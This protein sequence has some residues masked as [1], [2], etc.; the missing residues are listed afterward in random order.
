MITKAAEKLL[1]GKRVFRN[2]EKHLYTPLPIL[3]IYI[4]IFYVSSVTKLTNAV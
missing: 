2:S 1:A 4:F 3:L